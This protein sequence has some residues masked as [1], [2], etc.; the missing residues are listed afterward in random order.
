MTSTSLDQKFVKKGE[1][2]PDGTFYHGERLMS[3]GFM[4]RSYVGRRVVPDS[5][6]DPTKDMHYYSAFVWE[7]P[8]YLKISQSHGGLVQA[9]IGRWDSVI[10]DDPNI[11]G[12]KLDDV[13]RIES[14]T[15]LCRFNSPQSMIGPPSPMAPMR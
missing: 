9:G 15:D 7:I 8:L 10:F 14:K 1:F 3:L 11:L 6:N 13:N 5:N 4:G 2:S 12:F